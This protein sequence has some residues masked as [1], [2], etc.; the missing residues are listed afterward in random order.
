MD[1]TA[2]GISNTFDYE[3]LDSA[4]GHVGWL[5]SVT[6]GSLVQAHRGDYRVSA[7]LDI[8]GEVPPVNGYIRIWHTAVLDGEEA[9]TCLATLVPEPMDGDYESGR[10][11]G[12]LELYSGMKRMD[13]DL[14]VR[15][16][17]LAAGGNLATAW[18]NRVSG[19][20]SVPLVSS[21]ISAD[22]TAS[23]AMV[24]EFGGSWLHEAHIIADAL[25]GYIGVAD[26]GE[27]TLEKYVAPAR[28]SASWSLVTGPS[29]AILPGI[30]LDRAEVCNRVIARYEDNGR[31]Y[32]ANAVLDSSHPWSRNRIGRWE[33]ATLDVE[34]V[35]A[36]IQSNLDALAERELDARAGVGDVYEARILFDP[37]IRPGTVGTVVYADSPDDAGVAFKAFCSQREVALDA[38][39][40]TTLTLEEM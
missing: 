15:D 35:S 12:S 25:G 13:T 18:A 24:F 26:T 16:V 6:G 9:R 2:S 39:M 37:A 1:W 31:K 30:G 20:G 34:A 10:W 33:A 14:R 32:Y 19:A 7:S 17:G 4:L 38:G 29:S 11:T 23:R 22:A 3:V 27:V 21:S 5:D 40:V 28:R 36:P 8:D